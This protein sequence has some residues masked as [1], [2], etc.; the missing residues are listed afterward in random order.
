MFRVAG[1]PFRPFYVAL[2]SFLALSVFILAGG[3]LYQVVASARD[4]VAFPLPGRLVDVGG[5]RL[6]IQCSGSQSAGQPTVIL[7]S[8]LGAP[9]MMWTL[10]QSDLAKHR[11]VCSY[12]RAGYGWSDPGPEPRTARHFASE[13]HSLLQNA[14]EKPPYL[15]VA[16]SLGSLITRVYTADYPGEVVGLLFIDPRHE[17]FFERMPP[18]ALNIDTRNFQ[19]AR[20]LKLLTRTG[21]TR[22]LGNFGLL[23]DFEAFLAPL[24]DDIEAAAWARMIYRP[25]H[26]DTAVA[27]RESSTVTYAQA[28]TTHLPQDLPLVVLTAENGWQAWQ[29]G[30]ESSDQTGRATWF[31]LQE[32]QAHLTAKGKWQVVLGGGH[33]LYYEQ[34]GQIINAIDELLN[35]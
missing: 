13:L 14:G 19:N 10:V 9:G 18:E 28:G 27:E 4:E 11:R 33:Y 7:E 2:A 1:Q 31:A 8:G 20:W 3:L 17:A 35:R 6:H 30:N 32:E 22:A 25:A 12:D 34:P 23:S 5:Y 21:Y 24:P 26:W 16:H 15:L 29:T